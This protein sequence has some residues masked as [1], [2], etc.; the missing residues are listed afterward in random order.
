MSGWC[1]PLNAPARRPARGSRRAA[2]RLSIADDAEGQGRS[3]FRELPRAPKRRRESSDVEL[4]WD[5]PTE[6][7]PAKQNEV[8]EGWITRERGRHRGERGE[9]GGHFDRAA[10]GARARHQ[11]D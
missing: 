3:V 10:Q 5:G 7:D 4:I 1:A 6:L 11:G 8:V 9:P 2:P